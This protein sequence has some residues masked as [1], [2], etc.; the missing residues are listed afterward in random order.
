[1]RLKSI[2][3]AGLL[4]SALAATEAHATPQCTLTIE[5]G[6][7]IP[8]G[9]AFS[10][11]IDMFDFGP[12]PPG[13]FKVLFFGTKNGVVDTPSGGEEY[14]T[15]FHFGTLEL[16]GY[17]NPATGGLT[18]DYTRTAVLFYEDGSLYCVSNQVAVT[19]Q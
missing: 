13:L 19:L 9:W 11:R 16:T 7:F 15:R 1:M 3:A 17:I 6:S 8:L 10:F 5:P 18:G 14:P 2:L 12:F 4:M